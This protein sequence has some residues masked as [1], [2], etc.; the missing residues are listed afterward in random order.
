V[1]TALLVGLMLLLALCAALAL[2]AWD[3]APVGAVG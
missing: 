2:V 1:V 3:R